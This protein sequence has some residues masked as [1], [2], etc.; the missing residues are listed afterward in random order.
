MRWLARTHIFGKY[1]Q[2]TLGSVISCSENLIPSRSRPGT[3]A[4]L[5]CLMEA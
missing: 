2:I 1:Q 5:G 3:F 4:G